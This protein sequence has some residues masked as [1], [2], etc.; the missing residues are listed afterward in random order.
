L[1]ESTDVIAFV[2]YYISQSQWPCVSKST[3]F[4]SK[5]GWCCGVRDFLTLIRI[6]SL[7]K[8]EHLSTSTEL[9]LYKAFIS[10]IMTYAYPAW[11]IRTVRH[12]LKLLTY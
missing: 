6:C 2:E 10:S 7:L 5:E 12:L 9:T 1:A 8:S 4:L 11:E 3:R